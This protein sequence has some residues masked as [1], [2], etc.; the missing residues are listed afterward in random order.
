MTSS[1]DYCKEVRGDIA[2]A[3]S[4]VI[5]DHIAV[6]LDSCLILLLSNGISEEVH[7]KTYSELSSR[8]EKIRV[9]SVIHEI[10][11]IA[12]YKALQFSKK[13]EYFYERGIE[14]D[15]LIGVFEHDSPVS[16]PVVDLASRLDLLYFVASS[17][18]NTGSLVIHFDLKRII[19]IINR[20]QVNQYEEF[21]KYL[22]VKYAR[23][24]NAYELMRDI[25]I[26]SY[27][28]RL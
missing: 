15:Y 8:H 26:L 2:K 16:D 22:E 25:P 23:G 10:P 11:L 28:H 21:K 14:K 17:L 12:L 4:R 20:Q 6:E 3:L 1:S 19:A 13:Q 9:V 18:I 24:N 27:I 7:S 5:G